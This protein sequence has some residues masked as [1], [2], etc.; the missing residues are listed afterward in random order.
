MT[1]RRPPYASVLAERLADAGGYQRWAGTSA[2]GQH[3]T[4]WVAIGH[5][6]WTWARERL[7]RMLCT[8]CPPADDPSG[9]DWR[10][11]AGHAPVCVIRCGDVSD[12][13]VHALAAALLRDGVARVLDVLTGDLHIVEV[14][15]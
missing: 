15:A 6:A 2:D 7:D 4:I 11:L 13:R 14:A 10:C 1:R 12:D 3:V 5:G 9:Y 8:L